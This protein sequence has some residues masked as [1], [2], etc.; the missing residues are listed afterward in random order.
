MRGNSNEGGAFGCAISFRNP[1]N[2]RKRA[3]LKY[4]AEIDGLRAIAVVPV[5][6]FHAGV[7]QFAGGFVGV[8]I[9]FV[10]SGYLITTIIISDIDQGK[11]S[12]AKFYE[13]RARRI[14]PA[15]F[16]VVG[17]CIPFAWLLLTPNYMKDFLQSLVS[18]ATFS[19]N[20]LFWQESGYF[21]PS[22]ELKPLLHTWSLAVE[23]QYYI[24]FPLILI[25]SWKFGW[26]ATLATL[27]SLFVVSLLVAH[28][29]ASNKPEAAFFLLPTRGWE[30]LLGAFC[31]FYLWKFSNNSLPAFNQCGS[32]IGITLIMAS[33]FLFDA[34]TPMP[35][36]YAL[37][38]TLG[39]VLVILCANENSIVKEVL[40]NR[41][42]VFVG[43]ISYSAYLWHQPLFAFAR[44]NSAGDIG[45]IAFLLLVFLTFA[46]A[47]LSWR[48]IETP[49]RSGLTVQP[50]MLFSVSAASIFA[51]VSIGVSWQKNVES[52]SANSH[53]APNI[54][55]ASLGEKIKSQGEVCERGNI[56][57]TKWL[58]GCSF[59]DV[60]AKKT[61]ILYGDSHGQA[62]AYSLDEAFKR[63]R[64]KGVTL[65]VDGCEL[66]P[67]FRKN[68]NT[69]VRNCGDRFEELLDFVQ[70]LN[71]DVIVTSRWMFWLYPIEGY[72]LNMPYRNSEGYTEMEDYRQYDVLI[73]GKFSRGS[74]TKRDYLKKFIE[75]LSASS[76]NLFFLYPVPETGIDIEKFNRLHL[77]NNGEIPNVISIPLSDY[78][79]RNRFVL[80]VI[81][82]MDLPNI[83]KVRIDNI[84][85]NSFVRD[86]CVIQWDGVPYYYDDDHLS[87][88]GAN[89][90]VREIERLADWRQ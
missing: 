10:I 37:V 52:I 45:K 54:E 26:K 55:W 79:L 16:F 3:D 82:N 20:I 63:K 65:G 44:H 21:D 81:D 46:L 67:Y 78:K 29:A 75:K 80:D 58:S 69:S 9:F 71:T 40:S 6:L 76:K 24:I 50:K 35:G 88:E 30:L 47:Y 22:S 73:D 60:N 12:L 64:I 18:V 74:E 34:S 70:G 87:Y 53:Y 14:L 19:S 5:I 27:V 66:I 86:R 1:G 56:A 32:L 17:V 23:E 38:P 48:Y 2:L 61:I 85:C 8:D 13:R 28:W 42:F 4:R 41:A 39:A 49:F 7:E 36:L 89:L 62:L 51:L 72:N 59:G 83:S 31:A 77:R 57:N 33:I 90:V 68:K 43:L 84:F 25:A 15:L 11:F